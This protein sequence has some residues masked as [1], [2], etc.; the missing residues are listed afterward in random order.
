MKLAINTGE[1]EEKFGMK[2]ALKMIKDAGFDAYDISL[3]NSTR[4]A[5]HFLRQDNYMETVAEIKECAD[6]L[7]L[8]CNQAHSPFPSQY[9]GYEKYNND[10]YK[11]TVRCLEA[12]AY[13]GAD[14]VVVHPIKDLVV[15][16]SIFDGVFIEPFRDEEALLQA[17][18]EFFN[19]L[20]PYCEKY[21]IKVALENLFMWTSKEYTTLIPSGCGTGARLSKYIDTINSKWVIACLD[22]GHNSVVGEDVAN[23]VRTLGKD[24][25]MALHIQDNH[26]KRDDHILPYMG[27]IKWEGVLKALGE[28]DYQGDFTFETASIYNNLPEELVVD[29]LSFV[30]KVGRYM[31]SRIEEYRKNR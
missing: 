14:A 25:L 13:L 2:T 31:M 10:S 19:R 20:I 23:T 29:G 22:T 21:G 28:I 6:S 15:G 4:Q 5:D 30:A 8:V 24:R 17:N 18:V 9:N 1:L 12:A 11:H 3:H 26:L 7:G 27:E 16:G